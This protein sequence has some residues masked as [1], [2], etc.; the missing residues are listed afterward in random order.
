MT[1]EHIKIFSSYYLQRLR[2]VIM[3]QWSNP[4][5]PF[6]YELSGVGVGL[7]IY[8]LKPG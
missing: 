3:T 5:E 6:Y 7:F 1:E 8:F 2:V 4:L